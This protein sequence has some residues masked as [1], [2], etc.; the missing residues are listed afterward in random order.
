MALAIL[1]AWQLLTNLRGQGLVDPRHAAR[2]KEFGDWVRSC[3]GS[4]VAETAGNGAVFHLPVPSAGATIDR[5]VIRENQK[6]GQRIRAW[7]V[8]AQVGGSWQPF[9]NGTGVGNRYTLVAGAS[10]APKALR[11]TV[12]AAIAEP[13]LMQFAA[14]DAAPCAVPGET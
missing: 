7:H 9:G 13:M 6:F 3:Y 4:P 8:E 10:V 2:Y 11:L 5:V 12:T 14:F 1:W